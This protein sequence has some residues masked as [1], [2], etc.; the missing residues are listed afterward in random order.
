MRDAFVAALTDA[1]REDPRIFLLT[2]DLGYSVLEKFAA[3]F[4]DRFINAGVAENN[5][6]GMAAGLAHEGKVAFVYSIAQFI[7]MRCVEHVRLD[8]CLDGVNVKLV[9]VG[10]GL[11][12]GSQGPTHHATED[13][14]VMRSLP[15]LTVLAPA[16]PVEAAWAAR[17]AI[18]TDGPVYIRLGKSAEPKLY[19]SPPALQVGRAVT[20]REGSDIA[21]IATGGVVHTALLSAEALARRGVEARVLSMHTLKPIDAQA[22]LRAAEEVGA[23]VT[24]EEHNI[25]GG[26][27]SAVAEVLAESALRRVPFRRLGIPDRFVHEVGSQEY[28][29]NLYGLSPEGIA[30]TVLAWLPSARSYQR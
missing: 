25:V 13:L 10:G 8:V 6:I 4:P 24:I 17:A 30:A 7:S 29:R 28:L 12:Y 1:A 15:G 20:L 14:A 21:L 22:I 5:M 11:A 16:D 23:I 27:G 2:G 26:L 18:A 9:G 3:E 19:Q